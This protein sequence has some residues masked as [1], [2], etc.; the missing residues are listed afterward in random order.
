MKPETLNAIHRMSLST[1]IKENEI[2]KLFI[3]AISGR[4]TSRFS[5]L[6]SGRYSTSTCALL[7]PNGAIA[8]NDF[9][10]PVHSSGP[11][12]VGR[13]RSNGRHSRKEVR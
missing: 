6:I 9:D 1:G 12:G 11:K 4:P 13:A 10:Q 2:I 8:H 3:G 5:F 7:L